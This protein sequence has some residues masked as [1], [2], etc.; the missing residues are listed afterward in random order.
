ME[1]DKILKERTRKG[2]KEV[3]VSWYQ[4]PSKYNSWIKKSELINM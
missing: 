2:E 1:V 3:L 4:W